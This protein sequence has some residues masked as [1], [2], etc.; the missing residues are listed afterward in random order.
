MKILCDSGIRRGSDI[1]KALA[2]GANSVLIGRPVIYALATA[3]AMGVAH[4]LRLLKDELTLTM[5]LT[6]CATISDINIDKIRM[7]ALGFAPLS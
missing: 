6:G 2:L 3:G 7:P 1:F 5:T 4:C